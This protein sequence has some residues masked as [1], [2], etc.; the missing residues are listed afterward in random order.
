MVFELLFIGKAKFNLDKF[1]SKCKTFELYC[2]KSTKILKKKYME[3]IMEKNK[4]WEPLIKW[5]ILKIN[6]FVVILCAFIE[7]HKDTEVLI[8]F[9]LDILK[10]TNNYNIKEILN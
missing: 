10:L 4:P 7:F 2:Q 6:S 5:M 9:L 1:D 3:E 8:G